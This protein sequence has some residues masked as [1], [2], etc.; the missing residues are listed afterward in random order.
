MRF[1]GLG[2]KIVNTFTRNVSFGGMGRV[3]RLNGT[4]LYGLKSTK[5]YFRSV[6]PVV[7]ILL[8]CKIVC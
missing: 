1:M 4:M 5:K 8:L 6:L 3:G 7:Y 2:P